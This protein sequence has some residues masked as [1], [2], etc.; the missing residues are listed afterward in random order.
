MTPSLSFLYLWIVTFIFVTNATNPNILED[1]EAWTDDYELN[2][3]AIDGWRYLSN[4]NTITGSDRTY[5]GWFYEVYK[6]ASLGYF[7]RQFQCEYDSF[8]NVSFTAYFGCDYDLVGSYPDGALLYL[9][10]HEFIHYIHDESIHNFTD[11]IAVSQTMQCSANL[12]PGSFIG[13]TSTESIQVDAYSTVDVGFRMTN[14]DHALSQE[15][16][17][18][19]DITIQ[20][21]RLDTS[22]LLPDPPPQVTNTA[23]VT[24]PSQYITCST[25]NQSTCA[26][27]PLCAWNQHHQSQCSCS[28]SEGV[29]VIFGIGISSHIFDSNEMKQWLSDDIIMNID[30]T[31][32]R[33][34]LIIFNENVTVPIDIDLHAGHD[35][36]T[37]DVHSISWPDGKLLN[38]P[39]F[40]M[41]VVEQFSSITTP[42]S[43]QILVIVTDNNPDTPQTNG[44]ESIVCQ[45][46]SL[47]ASAGIRVIVVVIDRLANKARIENYECITQYSFDRV[48]VHD[49]ET[50]VTSIE[51]DQLHSAT[52]ILSAS[53]CSEPQTD[54][55]TTKPTVLPTVQPSATTTITTSSTTTT[56]T[57]HTSVSR[58]DTVDFTVKTEANT[59]NAA[60]TFHIVAVI[61]NITGLDSDSISVVSTPDGWYISIVGTNGEI[62][63]A[64]RRVD[65]IEEGIEELTGYDA[66]VT[67]IHRTYSTESNDDSEL[68]R[69]LTY[70]II[71][72]CVLIFVVIVISGVCGY[73][74]FLKKKTDADGSD[75][76]AQPT[77]VSVPSKTGTQAIHNDAMPLAAHHVLN[78]SNYSG[79]G[80]SLQKA[81]VHRLTIDSIASEAPN[82]RQGDLSIIV[83]SNEMEVNQLY[84]DEQFPLHKQQTLTMTCTQTREGIAHATYDNDNNYEEDDDDDDDAYDDMYVQPDGDKPTPRFNGQ[85]SYD[86]IHQ[87]SFNLVTPAHSAQNT[88]NLNEEDLNELSQNLPLPEEEDE[89]EEDTEED[90]LK[91]NYAKKQ[92]RLRRE[93]RQCFTPNTTFITV[94]QRDSFES[95]LENGLKQL[96]HPLNTYQRSKVIKW[97][98]KEIQELH[99]WIY[100]DWKSKEKTIVFDAKWNDCWVCVKV[101]TDDTSEEIK[102]DQVLKRLKFKHPQ[103]LY[104][105]ELM[106]N[107]TMKRIPISFIVSKRCPFTIDTFAEYL[108]SDAPYTND[109]KAQ[110]VEDLAYQVLLT[111]SCLQSMDIFHRDLKPENVLV[112]QA[113]DDWVLKV[114]D[115]GL[116]KVTT[117]QNDT[118][119]SN[120]GTKQWHTHAVSGCRYNIQQVDNSGVGLIVLRLV[121]N[122]HNECVRNLEKIRTGKNYRLNRLANNDCKELI[123]MALDLT[124]ELWEI[125]LLPYFNGP[126]R[127]FMH[128][129]ETNDAQKLSKDNVFHIEKLAFQNEVLADKMR[130]L[131]RDSER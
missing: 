109:K 71:A 69:L 53:L 73:C 101:T 111:V 70:L 49:Y 35:T 7:Y 34:G 80:N 8:I 120:V 15:F 52:P 110:I 51:Y 26:Q 4:S 55:P 46:R 96:D 91:A 108:Q 124:K 18:I 66:E 19:S 13:F 23:N 59:T 121:S 30:I 41:T 63:I 129:N 48:W 36:L 45:Y 1:G 43:E 47:L 78:Y 77:H 28:E 90:E 9:N 22:Q 98:C 42:N 11:V 105:N 40:F 130:K 54:S 72:V 2:D 118:K 75:H 27:S 117:R 60:V 76:H 115:F 82:A 125:K 104:V 17:A 92:V 127:R 94:L 6:R 123:E 97:L 14:L 39:H 3:N 29:D 81:S 113:H 74:L 131:L 37:S 95:F 5:H 20:C 89:E 62:N 128:T 87:M 50:G 57:A 116:S 31:H 58:L 100:I 67:R 56:L 86:M 24:N 114:M 61:A 93:E 12:R 88:L 44:Q 99:D 107:H 65:D 21:N 103:T 32:S 106:M 79:T 25:S 33:F 84:L 119:H 112:F 68:K 122:S 10:Q 83:G 85:P 38:Y 102:A 16:G 64:E 126:R